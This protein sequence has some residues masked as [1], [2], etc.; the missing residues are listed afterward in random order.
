MLGD[1]IRCASW[2]ENET[3]AMS[4]MPNIC[5]L[6]SCITR[7]DPC[8]RTL[9]RS[10]V[11]IQFGHGGDALGLCQ[12]PPMGRRILSKWPARMNTSINEQLDDKGC[13][14]VQSDSDA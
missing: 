14:L 11:A 7:E 2:K 13:C 12:V 10:S 1:K 4:F 8:P 6:Q 9:Y 3:S 5:R